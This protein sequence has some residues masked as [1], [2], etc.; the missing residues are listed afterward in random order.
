[1]G[2]QGLCASSPRHRR[3]SPRQS[4]YQTRSSSCSRKGTGDQQ[5]QRLAKRW[6][7]KRKGQPKRRQL[8]RQGWKQREYGFCRLDGQSWKW[9]FQEREG[10]PEAGGTLSAAFAANQSLKQMLKAQPGELTLHRTYSSPPA[11][12]NVAL[13]AGC[14]L[15]AAPVWR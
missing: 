10:E 9:S 1:M 5:G 2:L 3:C 15:L 7:W 12:A 6:F 8:Q 13:A 11:E 4:S 14:W